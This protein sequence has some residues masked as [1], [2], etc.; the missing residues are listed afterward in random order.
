M[1]ATFRSA[2]SFLRFQSRPPQCQQLSGLLSPP[3]GF[4]PVSRRAS[5]PWPRS[6]DRGARCFIYPAQRHRA[7]ARA[8]ALYSALIHATFRSALSSLRFQS[9]QPQSPP[10]VASIVR[11]GSTVFH[12]S[13]SAPQRLYAS[14]STLWCFNPTREGRPPRR[15]KALLPQVLAPA[16][17]STVPLTV[18]SQVSYR[19]ASDLLNPIIHFVHFSLNKAAG[20]VIHTALVLRHSPDGALLNSSRSGNHFVAFSRLTNGGSVSTGCADGEV[21]ARCGGTPSVPRSW[22]VS[23]IRRSFQSKIHKFMNSQVNMGK[24]S[25]IGGESASAST[26]TA[27]RALKHVISSAPRRLTESEVACCGSRSGKWRIG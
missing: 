3:S 1:P 25:E 24:P 20:Y 9:R 7:S 16:A 19:Q 26:R 2:L 5:S 14:Q 27:L 22:Q 12:L 23:R 11:S 18:L 10:T 4:S 13:S 15:P 17:A 21:I 8:K 6:S